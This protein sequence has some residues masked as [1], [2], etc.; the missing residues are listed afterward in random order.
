MGCL[1]TCTV[2]LAAA[3]AVHHVRSASA[4]ASVYSYCGVADA[5]VA[6][7]VCSAGAN[8]E[9][10]TSGEVKSVFDP[11]PTGTLSLNLT[12]LKEISLVSCRLGALASCLRG[13]CGIDTSYTDVFGTAKNSLESISLSFNDIQS[14]P[15]GFFF[16]LTKVTTL[17]LDGNF[18]VDI[19][20]RVFEGLDSLTLLKMNE[21]RLRELKPTYFTGL[22][23]L[24]DLDLS[25][26]DITVVRSGTF[27][28]VTNLVKLYLT[29]NRI[30]AIEN[31]TP[32]PVWKLGAQ[33]SWFERLRPSTADSKGNPLHCAA[34]WRNA[35]SNL[36]Q[37]DPGACLCRGFEVA[38][39]PSMSCVRDGVEYLVAC[40]SFCNPERVL[41][42]STGAN[43]G[44]G[45]GSSNSTVSSPAVVSAIVVSF[46]T[47]IVVSM[48]VVRR[49]MKNMA[50][51]RKSGDRR[52]S[53]VS[54]DD[55]DSDEYAAH[56][57]DASPKKKELPA[58]RA[59]ALRGWAP[60]SPASQ[61]VDED[62]IV[63]PN[64][65]LREV[66]SPAKP[67]TPDRQ[68]KLLEES[69]MA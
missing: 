33:I 45:G 41:S 8:Q 49:C 11:R 46:V 35:V 63:V 62:E 65:P 3:L 36:A 58:L 37:L 67:W 13:S 52:H 26:N 7:C 59:A 24:Q 69:S 55:P 30:G 5:S 32:L 61:M 16:G 1:R 56:R 29:R 40:P 27:D 18:I 4:S 34:N 47:F 60:P 20:A 68:K 21:N 43:N 64:R 6:R 19:P 39:T 57:S 50:K 51:R 17:K 9:L 53:L 48:L 14:M 25:N 66:P 31:L 12:S 44:G 10:S 2:L 54:P 22:P 23:L 38:D 28:M 42:A 15:V